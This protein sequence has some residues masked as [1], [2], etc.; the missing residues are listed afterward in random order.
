MANFELIKV[1][2][3]IQTKQKY[4]EAVF[5]GVLSWSNLLKV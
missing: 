1:T 2:V 3:L 5:D 4:N